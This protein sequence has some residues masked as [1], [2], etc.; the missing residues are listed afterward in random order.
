MVQ[1]YH[2]SRCYEE[3]GNRYTRSVRYISMMMGRIMG[4]LSMRL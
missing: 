4:L 1:G 2:K 3:N